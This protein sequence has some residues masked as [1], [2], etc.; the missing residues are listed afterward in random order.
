LREMSAFAKDDRS[1][2]DSTEEEEVQSVLRE[3]RKLHSSKDDRSDED[4]TEEEEDTS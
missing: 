4:S 2:E 1:D 3:M